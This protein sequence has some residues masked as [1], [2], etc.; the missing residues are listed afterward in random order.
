MALLY[1]YAG[2][3][4]VSTCRQDHVAIDDTSSSSTDSNDAAVD[5]ADGSWMESIRSKQ[6]QQQ[7]QQQL[8][9]LLN[10]CQATC[11]VLTQAVYI[12]VGMLEIFTLSIIL[13]LL[14]LPCI[15]LWFL[16]QATTQ[17]IMQEL[18][19]RLESDEDDD[20]YDEEEEDEV[21]EDDGERDDDH[22]DPERDNDRFAN[23][24]INSN[25]RNHP[26]RHGVTAKDI[27]RRLQTVQL[28]RL[29]AKELSTNYNDE[30]AEILVVPIE[31]EDNHNN[32][33]NLMDKIEQAK[34]N[35]S[36]F[37]TPI[38]RECCICMSEFQISD[39]Y[40]KENTS[41]TDDEDLEI[42]RTESNDLQ[43]TVETIVRTPEC[44]H[45]FHKQCIATWV[46]GQWENINNRSSGTRTMP[47]HPI[48]SNV[49]GD[50]SSENAPS[51]E[52]S[53]NANISTI[54]EA[55]ETNSNRYWR[56]IPNNHHRRR[57]KRTTCP[58]CRADLSGRSF[59]TS[60]RNSNNT[61]NFGTL[62]GSIE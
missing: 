13:P 29:V 37:L 22:H 35:S 18:Q 20:E 40:Q 1:V 43:S 30:E 15:Y 54:P 7:Q 11:P 36:S 47:H 60:S 19:Q 45:L 59:R 50:V 49:S 6:Q 58:L 9:L 28:I 4:L 21:D 23:I 12:Y 16:R 25:R 26:R 27:L 10:T 8:L 3:S 61:Q 32:D 2:I 51:E 42:G 31:D 56:T 34:R 44:R 5:A 24:F 17:Q 14:V 57:A 53:T 38:N 62:Y 41:C 52:V 46:G 39:H 48:R 55:L 33:N